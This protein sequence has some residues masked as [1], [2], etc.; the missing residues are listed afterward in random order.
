MQASISPIGICQFIL[1]S[2]GRVQSTLLTIR[3]WYCV[4]PESVDHKLKNASWTE[5]PIVRT[6]EDFQ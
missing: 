4:L 1:F 6:A 2:M 5:A 3:E